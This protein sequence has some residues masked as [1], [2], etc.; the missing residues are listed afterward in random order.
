M[1]SDEATRDGRKPRV[2]FKTLGC[3]L[4]QAETAAM[5]GTFRAAG[6]TVVPPG[7]PCDVA[8]VHTCTITARAESDSLR[9][10]RGFARQ[11]PRPVV[12]L[13]G[14]AVEASGVDMKADTGAD[15]LVGHEGKLILP[16]LLA[17]RHGLPPAATGDS[18]KTA[19][20]R[21]VTPAFTTTRAFV[22]VQDG[23]NFHCAYCI[24]PAARGRPVSRPAAAVLD[25][26]RTLAEQGYKEI[27]L[28]GANL[29]TYRDGRFRLVD[30][31]AAM[32]ELP[33]IARTRI[34]S[35][36]LSTTEGDILDFMSGSR[37]LCRHLHIPIQ[38]GDDDILTAMGRRYTSRDVRRFVDRAVSTLSLPGLGTDIITGFPGET[39]RHAANTLA[40]VRDLPFTRLHVFP[41]SPRP[42]TRAA[43]MPHR[44]PADIAAARAKTLRALGDA[45]RIAFA[46]QFLNRP[47]SVLVE[48]LLSPR[49]ACGWTAEYVR[50]RVQGQ[51]LTS[52]TLVAFHPQHLQND[53]LRGVLNRPGP[54][55]PAGATHGRP[56]QHK[57][58]A[59]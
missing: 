52:N 48:T 28:T 23:C 58:R 15:L 7:A 41:Y 17:G 57:N 36:E 10:A 14:C 59:T 49:A 29:G 45:K 34:S 44:P 56:V 37:K 39:G 3:R 40:L 18:A 35:I 50:A 13:A 54:A 22:K 30:L 20:Q 16:R 38:S 32:D 2:A 26:V 4:N 43:A 1:A 42:L 12:V 47:V 51:G 9:A 33:G 5:A 46:R 21:R 8:V 25:D 24:V 31:L 53:E 27:V 55:V 19:A 6:Y 11:T